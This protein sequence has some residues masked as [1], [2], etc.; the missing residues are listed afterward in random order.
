[1]WTE[2]IHFLS[3]PG[4]QIAQAVSWDIALHLTW[5]CLQPD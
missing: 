1:M 4:L 5:H 2:K 3:L